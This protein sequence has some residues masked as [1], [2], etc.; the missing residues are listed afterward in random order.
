MK[1]YNEANETLFTVVKK[2]Q[3]LPSQALISICE[4]I[5]DKLNQYVTLELPHRQAQ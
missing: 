2:L 4:T 1:E 5:L 3:S